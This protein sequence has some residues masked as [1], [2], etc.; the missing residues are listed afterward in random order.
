[1]TVSVHV[2]GGFLGA[3]KTTVVQGLL[4]GALAGKRVAIVINDFGESALD[5]G[6]LGE[7]GV[8]MAPINGVCV[9]CTAPE[10]FVGAVGGLLEDP[11][12]EVIL[13]EPSGLARPAD[14]IDTLRRAPFAE[15]L[16]IGPLIVLVDS[17]QLL[18]PHSAAV[19]DQ[20]SHA[21]VLVASR[22]DLS[23]AQ[24]HAAFD[25]FAASTWPSPVQVLRSSGGELNP[26]ALVWPE[27]SGLRAPEAGHCTIDHGHNHGHEVA[28]RA[29]SL[30]WPPG[31]VFHRVR[32]LALLS[33]WSRSADVLRLKAVVRSDEGWLRVDVAGGH[34][35]ERATD[36]RRDSRLDLISTVTE[37]DT[38]AQAAL[39]AAVLTDAERQVGAEAVVV[40]LPD[41]S[42]RR[43]DRAALAL[44]PDGVPDVAAVLPGRRGAAARLARLFDL[45]EVPSDV[46]AV[47]V[48]ADGY[49]TPAVPAASLRAGL[50]IHSLDGLPL[51]GNKGGPLR[52]MI[53]GDAGPGGPCANVKGVVRIALRAPSG[54]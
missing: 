35:H 12:L 2:I 10:G 34:V 52:L 13:V 17:E 47:V 50:L 14:L 3:G 18:G 46:E 48:A 51:P 24:A 9:C 45:L 44:L 38:G 28:H 1:M 21:D 42:A 15:H 41:G 6:L 39:N 4:S 31:T 30:V 33:Q 16:R 36:W 27:N 37:G 53:P 20:A 49:T 40:A 8:S 11:T 29:L 26:D 7:G 32:L 23:G 5:E 43:F 25:A 22:A 19:R 54:A